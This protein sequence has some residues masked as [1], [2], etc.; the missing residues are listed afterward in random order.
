MREEIIKVNLKE[1]S[2][3]IYIKQNLLADSGD[4]VQKLFTG[5]KI[6]IITQDK[7]PK[8]FLKQVKTSLKKAGFNVFTLVLPSGEQFKNLNSLLRII[9]YAI[10]NK[11]ER[12]DT[13]CALGGGVISDLT[14]FAASIYYR[15]INFICMPT[16]LLGM[17]DASI[18][19][20]TSINIKEG[21][22]LL[23]T[24]YQPKIILIDPNCLKTLSEKEFLV[25]MGEVIKYALLDKGD[26]FNFLTKNKK[27]ILRRNMNSLLKIIIHSCKVK[28]KIVSKDEKESSLRAILNL[29]HTFAHG[30]EQAYNY[31]KYTHGEAVSIGMCLA[32][33]LAFKHNMISE[34]KMNSII[35]LIK[36]YGLPTKISSKKKIHQITQSML[37]D[38]K[39]KGGKLRFLLPS[40]DIGKVKIVSGISINEIKPLF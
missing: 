31:K 8:I 23:G 6:L 16:T 39:I 15:G 7:V 10:R 38:K 1:K 37:L 25:G 35:K 22:N 32:S 28:A 18:G 3:N 5:K 21:K 2:Y 13:F 40:Q 30:I 11:F 14:G 27:N 24:F 36:N 19:G 34:N 9:N 20:K 33:K 29:G 4:Y 12:D 26:F 17:V